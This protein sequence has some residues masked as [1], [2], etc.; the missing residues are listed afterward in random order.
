MPRR[1]RPMK[2]VVDC[3]KLRGAVSERRSGDIRMGEPTQGNAWVPHAEYIGVEGGTEGTET[4]K[5]L[6][7]KRIFPE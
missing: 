3:E 2:D 7:E 5:Y 4:S 6:Q 1:Q